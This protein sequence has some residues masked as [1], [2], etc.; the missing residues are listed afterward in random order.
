[1]CEIITCAC[2]CLLLQTDLDNLKRRTAALESDAAVLSQQHAALKQQHADC[3]ATETQLAANLKDAR[4]KLREVEAARGDAAAEARRWKSALDTADSQCQSLRDQVKT[5]RAEAQAFE[6]RCRELQGDLRAQQLNAQDAE[7]RAAALAAVEK[8]L[9]EQLS[10]AEAA[11]KTAQTSHREAVQAC[12]DTTQQLE[13][14]RHRLQLAEDTATHEADVAARARQR[15]ADL[16][17]Q[18]REVESKASAAEA[19]AATL[20]G[21]ATEL[22]RQ[23]KDAV[24]ALTAHREA[25]QSHTATQRQL[26]GA[27]AAAPRPALHDRSAPVSAASSVVGL[28]EVEPVEHADGAAPPTRLG[29]DAGAVHGA[30]GSLVSDVHD[31]LRSMG[32]LQQELQRTK[33][34]AEDASQQLESEKAA[35]R[36]AV[37][38]ATR[39]REDAVQREKADAELREQL[40][41]EKSRLQER[42]SQLETEARDAHGRYSALSRRVMAM[43]ARGA[44]LVHV[45]AG[46]AG[47]GAGAGAPRSIDSFGHADTTNP[48]VL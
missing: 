36:A 43:E 6:D 20:K 39:V 9:T 29:A 21:E 5:M 16:Q 27:L 34:A 10:A 24:A 13:A 30:D 38:T 11:A 37:N 45:D 7:H 35:H 12:E 46:G 42:L 22:R 17:T 15:G 25:L 32:A 8:A 4:S 19:A 44:R 1:M 3:G 40:T 41:T 18:L 26:R 33:A 28:D 14:L 48:F 2:V 47:S 31:L 23:L